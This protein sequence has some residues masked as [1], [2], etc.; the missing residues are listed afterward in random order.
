MSPETQLFTPY[1]LVGQAY[2]GE[3]MDDGRARMLI[4][5]ADHHLYS[6]AQSENFRRRPV[7]VEVTDLNTQTQWLV[8]PAACSADCFC[9]AEAKRV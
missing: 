1:L 6:E 5:K 7:W 3:I 9:A 8:R 4:S 2:D